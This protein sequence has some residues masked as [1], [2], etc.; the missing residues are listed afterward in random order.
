VRHAFV[1]IPLL[2]AGC[3]DTNIV[4]PNGGT[5]G[6]AGYV[7]FASNREAQNFELYRIPAGGGKPERLT[8]DAEHNDYNPVPSRDG[9]LVAWER[10][11]AKAGEGV[12]STEIWVM[13][14]D[15]SHP[16][17]IVRN[18]AMNTSPSWTAQDT[19]LVFASDVGG[20]WD[21]YRISIASGQTVNLTRNAYADQAPRVSPDGQRVVFQ[22]NRT[23]DFEI[24]TMGLDGGDVHNLSESAA[25]DRFP[26]WSPDGKQIFWTRYLDSFNI[27]RMN[28]D[29]SHQEA[30]LASPFS[31]SAPAVSPDGT[32][33][34][35][36]SDRVSPTSL[37]VASL[38]GQRLQQ[39]TNLPGWV[40]GVDIDPIWVH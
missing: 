32:A 21:I 10:E 31:D 13:N 9:R 29:G 39:L 38:D 7:Y 24:Y 6:M 14:A 28:A 33:V 18:G 4:A 37:F 8:F 11:I 12:T 1:V 25:D 36:T 40:R 34:V 22:S 2:V 27:W 16:R 35:F 15:G 26:T 20:D 3:V 30:M 19:A 23:L 5:N 17:V